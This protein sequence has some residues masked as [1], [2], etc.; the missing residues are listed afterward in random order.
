MKFVFITG[1]NFINSVCQIL[2]PIFWGFYRVNKFR[3]DLDRPSGLFP[4]HS[5]I[6]M[7]ACALRGEETLL[8][9]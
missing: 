8:F 2:F 7:R 1:C 9:Y 6:F 3:L 4:H 5:G